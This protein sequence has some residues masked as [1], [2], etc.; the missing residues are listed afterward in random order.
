MSKILDIQGVVEGN[1]QARHAISPQRS[2]L[3]SIT[4]I[5]GSGKAYITSHIVDALKRT[6]L[7]AAGINIDGWL[8][9]PDTRFNKSNPGEHFY[10]HAIRFEE[11]FAQL[12][13]TLRDR[14]TLR[15]EADY[16]EE[17]ATTYH[18]HIYEFHD[19]DVIV[20][21]GIYAEAFLQELL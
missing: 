10:L 8:N 12:V 5:N 21:E 20:L 4:G 19:L 14:R 9:L 16:A 2:L 7:N 6:G 1:H 11:M 13:L 18:K 3:V 17:T 15:I